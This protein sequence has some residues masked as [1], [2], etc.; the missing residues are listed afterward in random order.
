[1]DLL[2]SISKRIVTPSKKARPEEDQLAAF[3]KAWTAV[4]VRRAL[5]ALVTGLSIA[6]RPR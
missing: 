2:K 5:L 3:H 6:C 1:M 4:Q